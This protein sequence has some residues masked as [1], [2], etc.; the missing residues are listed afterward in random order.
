MAP[1]SPAPALEPSLAALT[2]SDGMYDDDV[3]DTEARK[4]LRMSTQLCRVDEQSPRV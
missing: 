3:D 4:W 2:L 1:S